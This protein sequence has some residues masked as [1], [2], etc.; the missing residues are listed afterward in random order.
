MTKRRV[1]IEFDVT[2]ELENSDSM[3]RG[4]LGAVNIAHEMIICAVVEHQMDVLLR[5]LEVKKKQEIGWEQYYQYIMRF[6][7]SLKGIKLVGYVDKDDQTY[8]E[9]K[10]T[11]TYDKV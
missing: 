3:Y 9:N 1:V 6:H 8:L 7:E 11:L 10:K 5:A 2:D 4:D